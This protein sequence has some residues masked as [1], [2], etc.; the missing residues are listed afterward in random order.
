LD[1]CLLQLER[2]GII[3]ASEIQHIDNSEIHYLI[4]TTDYHR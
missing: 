1:K 3:H 4:F 2:N